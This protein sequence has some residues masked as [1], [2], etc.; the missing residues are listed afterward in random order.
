MV[1]LG[2]MTG[3]IRNCPMSNK[4]AEVDFRVMILLFDNYYSYLIL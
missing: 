4:D 1:F 2:V 3:F